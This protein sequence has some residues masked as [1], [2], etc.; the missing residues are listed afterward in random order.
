MKLFSVN[1]TACIHI[2]TPNHWF[3]FISFI[4]LGR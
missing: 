4:R 1:F 3:Q 2:S